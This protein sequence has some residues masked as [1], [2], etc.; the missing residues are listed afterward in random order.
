[1][2]DSELGIDRLPNQPM[3]TTD[4]Y[5]KRLYRTICLILVDEYH[6]LAIGTFGIKKICTLMTD[7][8]MAIMVASVL[9]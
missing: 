2:A 6:K 1:M 4:V 3:G 5:S 9:S 7:D 8:L